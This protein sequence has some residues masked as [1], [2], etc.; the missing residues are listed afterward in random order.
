MWEMF[1]EERDI[2][3]SAQMNDKDR[4]SISRLYDVVYMSLIHSFYIAL[5]RRGTI[6]NGWVGS[7]EDRSMTDS[8]IGYIYMRVVFVCLLV[9]CFSV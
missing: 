2:I 7:S 5:Y 1:R 3:V 4:Y 6:V 9:A 8:Y